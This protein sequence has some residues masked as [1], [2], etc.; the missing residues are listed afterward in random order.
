[1]FTLS[2][3]WLS[4]RQITRL[5]EK[6]DETWKEYSGMAVIYTWVEWLQ[7]NTVNYLEVLEE[8]NKLVVT[9]LGVYSDEDSGNDIRAV[10][11]FNDIENCIYEFLRLIIYDF[12]FKHFYSLILIHV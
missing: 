3:F 2:C 6:L 1:M 12:F 7:M 10:T 9:P 8:P 4:K 11:T 5:C